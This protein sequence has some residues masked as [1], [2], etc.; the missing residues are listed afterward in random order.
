[1][2]INQHISLQ[3][4]RHSL[5]L[6]NKNTIKS[7]IERGSES[8]AKKFSWRYGISHNE[9]MGQWEGILGHELGL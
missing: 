3:F 6:V 9:S 2:N 5:F 1:M 8:V 4:T 7:V